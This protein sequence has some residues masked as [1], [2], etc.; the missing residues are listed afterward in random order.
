MQVLFQNS[1]L[2]DRIEPC[3]FFKRHRYNQDFEFTTFTF[4]FLIGIF[5]KRLKT[6]LRL[7]TH[8][9]PFSVNFTLVRT[10]GY[11]DGLVDTS[12]R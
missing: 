12:S 10:V 6:L 9:L 2:L 8:I 4:A 3:V 7:L 1:A 5:S 11:M